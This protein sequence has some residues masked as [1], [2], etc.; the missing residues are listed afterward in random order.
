MTQNLRDARL[1]SGKTVTAIAA[2]IHSSEAAVSKILNGRSDPR[3]STVAKPA[4]AVGLEALAD[5][6]EGLGLKAAS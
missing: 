5:D 4:R 3:L 6:L 1:A 2:E